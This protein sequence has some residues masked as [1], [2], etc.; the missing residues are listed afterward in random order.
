[1]NSS[2]SSRIRIV[3]LCLTALVLH[4]AP[5]FS[6][7]YNT[8]VTSRVL[9]KT[10]IT[11]NGQPITYP[12]TDKAQVTAMTVELAPGAETGWH[13]HPVPVFAYVLSGKLVVDIEGGRQLSFAAGDAII[14]VVNTLHNGRN[15]GREPVKLAVFY[16]GS[17]GTPNVIKQVRPGKAEPAA[18]GTGI[19]K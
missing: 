9:V 17:E 1:M 7:D 5:A 3:C 18:T 8:G 12:V 11:G 4:V 6:A 19:E 15:A 10:S 16:L 14:E 2:Y 13:K